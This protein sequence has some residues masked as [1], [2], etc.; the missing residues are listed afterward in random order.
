MAYY[1][2]RPNSLPTRTSFFIYV[3]EKFKAHKSSKINF[4]SSFFIADNSHI[5]VVW[6]HVVFFS[7]HDI[8]HF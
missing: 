6:L 2:K 1:V 3:Q 4:S 7:D 5:K 8:L